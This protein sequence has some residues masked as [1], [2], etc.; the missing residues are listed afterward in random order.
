MLKWWKMLQGTWCSLQHEL[1]ENYQF[2]YLSKGWHPME[3]Y[4]TQNHQRISFCKTS[5]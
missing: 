2:V 5:C 3:P 4:G 1:I